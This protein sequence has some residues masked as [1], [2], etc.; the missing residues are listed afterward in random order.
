MKDKEF[1]LRELFTLFWGNKILI[2]KIVGSFTILAIIIS[3]ILPKSYKATA[4][5]LPPSS[6]QLPLGALGALGQFGLGSILGGGEDADR[7]VAI[8]KSQTLLEKVALKYNLQEKY[9][10]EYFDKTLE[11]LKDN[12]NVE[13][14]EENQIIV[15]L[16]DQ[17]QEE[18]ANMVNYVVQ[19]LDSLNIIY[20][21][22]KAKNN[23]QF[24]SSRL[25]IVLDS[26]LWLE[27]AIGDFMK[28]EGVLSFSDQVKEGISAAAALKTQ[29]L[30]KEI[31][32]AVAQKNVSADNPQIRKLILEIASLKS[33][34]Q[35]FYTGSPGDNLFPGLN[36]VPELGLKF[37]RLQRQSEYYIKVLEFL[38]P[39][40]EQAK[41]EEAKEIPTFQVLDYGK[42]PERKHKPKRAAIVIAVFMASLSITL[43]SIY[44]RERWKVKE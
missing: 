2:A 14:G 6:Q 25:E 16:V 12:M 4:V 41:I 15:D 5:I 24:I 28:E 26:L 34:Y 29:I 22:D 13:I 42:R 35:E 27:K 39:Q 11:A 38:A 23:R 18:V 3:L 10:E 36:D 7:F 37:T 19:C 31:N 1:T 9:G 8:L 44:F 43:Y 32:L 40:F 17:D 33:K 30:A 21:I 20:S